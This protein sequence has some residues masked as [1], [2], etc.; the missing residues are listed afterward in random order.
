MGN[1]GRRFPREKKITLDKQKYALRAAY[2]DAK[3]E[4]EKQKRLV[5][6]GK[7]RPTPLSQKYTVVLRWD[8][9]W[10]PQVWVVGNELQ[11][12]NH[13]DFPHKYEIREEQKMVRL[14]LYRYQEFSS[15]KLLC[16]TI[17]PWTVEWLYHYEIWL[18]TGEWCGGGEHPE[19]GEVKNEEIA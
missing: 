9:T 5:W 18:A 12:L 16:N 7:I 1:K 3:C 15:R 8:P 19:A 17:I 14:C 13:P 2:P 10:T 6:C 11:K 4:V